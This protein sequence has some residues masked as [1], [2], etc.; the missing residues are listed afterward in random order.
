MPFNID[1]LKANIDNYGYLKNSHFQVMIS[2]PRILQNGNLS[3]RGTPTS[4]FTILNNLKFRIE[5]VRTPGIQLNSAEI[6]RFGIGVPQKMPFSAVNQETSFSI[7]VDGYGE[8]Y[9]FWHAWIKAIFDHNGNDSTGVGGFANRFPN[10]LTEYKDNYSTIMQIVML[11]PYGNAI[12]RVNLI[13]AF[14]TS[15]REVPLAWS[16]EKGLIRLAVSIAFT[17]FTIVGS[18]LEG[19]NTFQPLNAFSAI[20]DSSRQF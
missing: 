11:D 12:Q 19:F 15:I 10:Y 9:Q 1:A 5:Q 3:N 14:P 13:E 8:I 16:D 4:V 6:P 7:L 2:P 20:L 17:E 18:A